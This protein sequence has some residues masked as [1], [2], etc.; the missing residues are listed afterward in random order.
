MALQIL[1][2]PVDKDDY[3]DIRKAVEEF[4]TD[5]GGHWFINIIK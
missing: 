5:K 4:K 1:I 2:S 3:K